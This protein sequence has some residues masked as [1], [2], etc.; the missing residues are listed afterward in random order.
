MTQT[1]TSLS[2]FMGSYEGGQKKTKNVVELDFVSVDYPLLVKE[3]TDKHGNP[4]MYHVIRYNNEDY[5]IPNTMLDALKE[6][7]KHNPKLKKFKVTRKGTTKEDT[8]YTFIPL[9]EQ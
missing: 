8:K 6:N 2:D 9:M 5:R 4:F 3:G 1:T 7:L